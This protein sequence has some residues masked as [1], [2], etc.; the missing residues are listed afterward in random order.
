[1]RVGLRLTSASRRVGAFAGFGGQPILKNVSSSRILWVDDATRAEAGG[2]LHGQSPGEIL[3]NELGTAW[4][5]DVEPASWERE[6][7]LLSQLGLAIRVFAHAEAL[8]G[9]IGTTPSARWLIVDERLVDGLLARQTMSPER[10]AALRAVP[11]VVLARDT[12]LLDPAALGVDLLVRKPLASPELVK[13]LEAH[14][15]QG[16]SVTLPRLRIDHAFMTAARDDRFA[17]SLTPREFQI[18]SLLY[19]TPGHTLTR[20]ELFVAVWSDVKV[21]RKA[22]DV[23][24]SKLRKKIA[25]LGFAI[26]FVNPASYELS[27]LTA[28]EATGAMPQITANEPQPS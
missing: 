5:L 27:T 8:L 18:L 4:V 13:A 3:Q 2:G 24:V 1:M 7:A 12:R 16:E 15:R 22:L 28:T 14:L 19:R 23:H 25:P 10:A 21:C 9:A 26:N 20:G 6:S 11:L 17:A